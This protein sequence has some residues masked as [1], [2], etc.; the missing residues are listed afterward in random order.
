MKNPSL[1]AGIEMSR[2]T[3][4]GLSWIVLGTILGLWQ[5]PAA[6]SQT[7]PGAPQVGEEY[8]NTVDKAWGLAVSGEKPTNTCAAIKGKIV[9][10]KDSSAA[11]LQ[12]L[13]ACNVEIPVRYFET[14]LDKVEAGEKTCINYMMEMTTQ[15]SAM[16][17]SADVL[18]EMVESIEES[19][20]QE[21]QAAAAE[22]LTAVAMDATA[23]QEAND[24]KRIIKMRLT[25]RTNEICPEVAAA[26]LN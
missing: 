6:W 3:R 18:G 11:A 10:K 12:A 15:L 17:M 8:Q 13:L 20:D 9:G 14:Y 19:G 23:E 22:A 7:P 4:V 16:T 24:P 26:V 2:S 1:Q 5:G 25:N 21:A